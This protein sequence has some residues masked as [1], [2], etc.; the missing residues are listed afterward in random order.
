MDIDESRLQ[1]SAN[2]WGLNI[3]EALPQ[4]KMISAYRA[5][6]VFW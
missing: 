3:P 5:D 2:A 1:R 6:R 4:A